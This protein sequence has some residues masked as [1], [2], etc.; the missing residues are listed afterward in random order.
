MTAQH[1]KRNIYRFARHFIKCQIDRRLNGQIVRKQIN[2]PYLSIYLYLFLP[3]HMMHQGHFV[4]FSIFVLSPS[5]FISDPS[6]VRDRLLA[7][8]QDKK[9]Y[10][11]HPQLRVQTLM[12][13]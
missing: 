8:H 2:H 7:L 13:F 11:I 6:T 10:I 9:K 12:R 3:L 4:N 5:W 1:T